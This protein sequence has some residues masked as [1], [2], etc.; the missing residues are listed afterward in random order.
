MLSYVCVGGVGG[1]CG[2]RAAQTVVV[3][4]ATIVDVGG[5]GGR[6]QRTFKGRLV[7]KVYD[8]T[9]LASCDSVHRPQL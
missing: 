6:E 5:G 3:V 7:L 8:T 2:V 4:V 9:Q 1:I